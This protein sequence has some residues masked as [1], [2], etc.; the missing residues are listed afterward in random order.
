[1][2][3]AVVARMLFRAPV[4]GLKAFLMATPWL[5]PVYFGTTYAVGAAENGTFAEMNRAL[6]AGIDALLEGNTSWRVPAWVDPMA[7]LPL[8]GAAIV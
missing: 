1:M 4:V 7:W 8:I 3:L 6:I 2:H 5:V